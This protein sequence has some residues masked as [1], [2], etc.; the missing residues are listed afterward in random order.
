M[1]FYRYAV[2]VDLTAGVACDV[3]GNH[4]NRQCA[5]S[6][7]TGPVIGWGVDQGVCPSAIV[8]DRNFV[9]KGSSIDLQR[10]HAALVCGTTD[11]RT[12]LQIVSI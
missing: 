4:L 6:K 10:D 5:I 12:V 7:N 1:L 8:P 9:R 3:G 11:E 2:V